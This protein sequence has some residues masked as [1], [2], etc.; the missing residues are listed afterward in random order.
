MLNS[1]TNL[2]FKAKIRLVLLLLFTIMTVLGILGAYFLNRIAGNSVDMMNSNLYTLTYTQEMWQA[3]NESIS[4]LATQDLKATDTR[5]QLRKSF[6]RFELYLG[7]QSNFI[8][9]EREQRLLDTLRADFEVFKYNI[10]AFEPRGEVPLEVMTTTIDMQGILNQVYEINRESIREKTDLAY[11]QANRVTLAMIIFGFFFFVFAVLAVFFFPES[12]ARP[13]QQL[14]AGI[15]EIARKNY[16]QRLEVR[17]QDEF[18]EVAHSFN[19]M[20]EKLAEYENL[21]VAKLLVEKR[22]IETIIEQLNEPIIGLDSRHTILFVNRKALELI[23]MREDE[24]LDRPLEAVAREN[25]K[26]REIV[27]EFL[28]GKEMEARSYPSFSLIPQ[29]KS[30]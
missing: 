16:G 12:I 23:G 14:T 3:L 15:R 30:S 2:N 11:R 7:L 9:Q 19:V 1:L 17:T 26:L 22:R 4:I 10:R 8:N 29:G 13:L 21:N 20:A 25:N 5:V 28:E 24:V 6:D 18:G 27:G